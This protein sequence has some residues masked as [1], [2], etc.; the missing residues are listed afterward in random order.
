[1]SRF[2]D[3]SKLQFFLTLPAPCPYLPE[4]MERKIFTALDPLDGPY[5][6]N[7]L[8]HSGF[9]RSQNVVY[10]PHCESCNACQ[11]LRVDTEAF[12]PT[13][14]FKRILRKNRDLHRSV[15]EAFATREQFDLLSKYLSHRHPNGGMSDLDFER[16][17]MMVEDSASATS[18]IE[19]RDDDDR[20]IACCITDQLNDGLS[21]VYS[22][23]D[24]GDDNVPDPKRRPQAMRN[25][26]LGT[27]MV[28][29]HIQLCSQSELPFLYLGY[30]VE[31][32]QK[33]GYKNR[34]KPNQILSDIGWT[35]QE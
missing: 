21:M 3:P 11:S 23:F 19:Y 17:E 7:Y 27:Y 29:D 32:S 4:Q 2:F 31:E 18:I 15:S 14:S 20:L 9:R 24:I 10:R 25:R 34:F 1:M 13:K 35:E 22:F 12:A 8:T 5:L 26:S 33:M 30:W 6:N 16:Y 28:L